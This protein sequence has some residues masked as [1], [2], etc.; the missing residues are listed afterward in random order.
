MRIAIL[1]TQC[2]FVIGGAELHAQGLV[3]AL[4]EAGH[5]A[6][7]VSMPFKWYPST[8]VLDHMLAARSLDVSEF[9]G[10]KIDLAIC[11][12]FPAYLM[13][14]PNKTFW[15]LHQHRQAYDLW[16]S[17]H[18]DLF[19]DAD[20]QVVREAIRQADNAELG[21][22][23]RIFANSANVARR[24]LKHNG[25]LAEPLYHPPPL[26]GRLR[27][28]GFGDYFY[29][30]SRISATKRQDFVLHSLA[31]TTSGFRV[32]FAGA[33]DDPE[34]GR[35]MMDLARDLG[36]AD[37]VEWRGFVSDA[38]MVDLYAG[39]RA[40]LFTPIDEDL[41]YVALEAM[42][43]GKPLLTLSDAGEPAVLV[44]DRGEGFVLPPQ[45]Q[46]FGEAMDHLAS[47]PDLARAMGAAGAERYR[48][49][50]I[51]WAHAVA[52]LTQEPLRAKENLAGTFAPGATAR[53][54]E[55]GSNPIARKDRTDGSMGTSL[56]LDELAQ[57][58]AFGDHLAR[59][60]GYYETHWPRYQ[61]TLEALVEAGVKPRRVLEIGSSAPYVFTALSKETFPDAEFTVVQE[62]PANLQWTH[63]ISGIEGRAP[64]IGVKLFGLNAETTPL[65]F[66]KGQ[67]DLVVA[68]E[69]LEH[70]AIDPSFVLREAHRV[71]RDGG[72][73]LV[74]TPNLVSLQ[75]VSRALEGASPYSFGLFVPWNGAYGRHNREYTPREV[76]GLGLY[77]GFATALLDTVDVY[78]Q[79]E[80]PDALR[81]FMIAHDHPLD[82][83][84]QNIV[85]IGRKIGEVAPGPCPGNLFPVDPAIFSGRLEL[86]RAPDLKDGY[87]VR[88][89]NKSPIRWL[90]EGPSRVRLSV[91][92][93]DQNGLVTT[94]VA[95]F[96]LPRDLG[97]E[98]SVDI[99]IRAI[100]N[101]SGNGC[102][103]E[104][105]LYAEGAGSFKGAGRTRSVSLF[106]ERL[107]AAPELRV[108]DDEA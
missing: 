23:A 74:T 78:R 30:P 51:S 17:G 63:E 84:G 43:A 86:S 5:E 24:L 101:A 75:G 3:Q 89:G 8:T 88:V 28:G 33:P 82:L 36:V 61:A 71:L 15:I 39:A 46:A 98:D 52:R 53:V 26:A 64:N 14:H 21:N 9:N 18:S 27:P 47:S 25:V 79:N 50:D 35:R 81:H 96:D 38:E 42:L 103:L 1:T 91:D 58:Y 76:E 2:P 13:R 66:A 19:D 54:P 99:P 87:R 31:R 7:I 57:R 48:A 49:L 6:E 69:I 102:W 90:Q 55:Q 72:A 59:H 11:L 85:Y 83:R 62:S 93:I 68:M 32:V 65:P 29:Y 4:R 100:A 95:A 92:R 20:G 80:V 104:I 12:K 16:D 67:F 40:V 106:A 45:A 73:L 10:V 22:G 97:P 60:R 70:F 41:G 56:S 34:Y 108:D 105:N 77:A 37:R 107:E 44:R 94:D